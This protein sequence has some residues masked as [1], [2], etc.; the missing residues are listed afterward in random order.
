MGICITDMF[1]AH[2]NIGAVDDLNG[3]NAVFQLASEA[4]THVLDKQLKYAN[5]LAATS[6]PDSIA[7]S[8]GQ[9][10]NQQYN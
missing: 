7:P 3:K 9:C 5:L 1:S 6:C 4:L 8:L 2:G 10:I